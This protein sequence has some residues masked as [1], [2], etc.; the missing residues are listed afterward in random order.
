[1]KLNK[2]HKK[3]KMWFVIHFIL[4][5]SFAIPLFIIPVTFLN[6]LGWKVVDPITTRMVAAALFAIGIESFLSRHSSMDSYKT[7]LMLKI[8]WSSTAIIGLFIGLISGHFTLL[9]SGVA[10]LLIFIIFNIVWT[11]WYLKIV[12]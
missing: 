2:V 8:I 10:L 7:M 3:L 5:I 11:Y 1:M 9:I 12:K 6:L 4:D